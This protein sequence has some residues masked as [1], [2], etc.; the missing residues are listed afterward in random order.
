MERFLEW[1]KQF[2]P[3]KQK[4]HM[5][6]ADSV[7]ECTDKQFSAK[8]VFVK[9]EA[10]VKRH[11]PNWAPR[12][13]Y[14]SSDLHNALLGPIMQECTKRMFGAM[15]ADRT[16]DGLRYR[17][18][19]KT[20]P[21]EIVSAIE[22]G[23]NADAM[24]IES[25][26]SS[27]DMKQVSDV[28]LIE[29]MW[30]RRFGAPSWLTALMI[31]ANTIRISSRKH[32]MVGIVK[33]Q[34]PT[35]A[36]STTFRNSLWNMTINYCFALRV[37][38]KGVVLILG[39]D[40]SMRFDNPFST[41]VK[42][43]RREYEYVA[44]LAK[45]DAKVKVHRRLSDTTFLSRNF[46]PTDKGHVMLP[47]LGKALVRFNVRATSNSGVSDETYLAG[48]ALSYAYEF[49]YSPDIAKQFYNLYL[50]LKVDSKVDLTDLGW[51]AKGA[52]LRY[53]VD[54]VAARVFQPERAATIADLSCFYD[55][56]AGLFGSEVIKLVRDV[57][58][59][60]DDIDETRLGGL[61]SDFM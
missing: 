9:I 27:N 52:F 12:I 33:N 19:Y 31:I 37:G 22:D 34:L 39:D 16:A 54:G 24:Y 30:L 35:G 58:H 13:I 38:A 56:K 17:G 36:Q 48:K 10:L 15:K 5:L 55:A 6:V 40:M 23:M 46:V 43:V 53:G 20:T 60:I 26:F 51:F 18:G 2:S 42:N 49:R 1:N 14:Q 28:H 47:M 50:E 8:Q 57:V 21:H 4:R 44:K 45:M 61:V 29:I 25:D 59:G 3:E 41:K 32:G 11:D 7:R